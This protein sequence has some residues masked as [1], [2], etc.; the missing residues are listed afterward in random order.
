V[1]VFV[2]KKLEESAA[3]Q[4]QMTTMYRVCFRKFFAAQIPHLPQFTVYA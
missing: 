2:M 4:L 3:S 1:S